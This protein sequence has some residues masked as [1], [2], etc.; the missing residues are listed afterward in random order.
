MKGR[1]LAEVAAGA[2]VLIVAAV[3]LVYAVLHSG[4]GTVT[5][6]GMQLSASFDRIDG[7]ANGADVRIAGVKVGTVTTSRIDPET[8]AAVL[9]LRVD[10]SLKLPDDTSAE[11][12]SEGL[13][14]GKYVSL[15]PGGSDKLLADGGRITQTQ[16]SVSLESLLGRFIFSVTQMNS[17][18]ATQ[19]G[20]QGAAAAQ[21]AAS[22]R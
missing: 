2:A 19:N 16:G 15:V 3:F 8:F 18:A 22:H 21:G 12:T 9:T 13:L 14:G 20:E 6:D 17:Q 7:L 5:A 11:V 10:P 1:S 4:R